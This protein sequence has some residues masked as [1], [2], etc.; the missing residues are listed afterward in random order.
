[1]IRNAE[2][3][4]RARVAG[5]EPPDQGLDYAQAWALRG[6]AG[7]PLLAR[8]LVFRVG[9]ASA[10]ATSRT[11][12]SRRTTTSVPLLDLRVDHGFLPWQ[13]NLW[14]VFERTRNGDVEPW[15]TGSAQPMSRIIFEVTTKSMVATWPAPSATGSR[16]RAPRSRKSA[17]TSVQESIAT[18]MRRW[19]GPESSA[20]ISCAMTSLCPVTSPQDVR[21]AGCPL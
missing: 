10:S 6:I 19:N 11:T 16:P 8:R 7:H 13:S 5:V 3:R 20:C 12:T 18:S 4:R 21:E 2:I 9:P 15:P 1:M 14:Y 17:A